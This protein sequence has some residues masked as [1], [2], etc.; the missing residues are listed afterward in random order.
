MLI[1]AA[2]TVVLTLCLMFTPTLPV[3]LAII[4]FF[5]LGFA[6]ST[7]IL[8]Y[9]AITE[10]NSL[11]TA[12][13]ALGFASVI[14]MTGPAVFEPVFGH[15]LDVHWMGALQNG[16]RLY[17]AHAFLDAFTIFPIAG[18][19]AYTAIL[20]TRK[21]PLANPFYNLADGSIRKE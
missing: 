18:I 12:G 21:N 15:I 3:Y 7:Q 19:L 6:S 8:G 2:I 4:L 17:S 10:R 16:V 1:G 14:I 13:S 11:S 5:G 20:L 9:P